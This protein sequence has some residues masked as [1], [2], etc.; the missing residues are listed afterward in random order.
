VTDLAHPLAPYASDLI[1]RIWGDEW[2][3]AEERKLWLAVMRFQA[4][5]GIEI[6][7]RALA[8]YADASSIDLD[9]IRQREMVTKHDVKA[10]LEEYNH[11]AS[12]IYGA[13]LELAH[14][15]MTSADVVDNISLVQMRRSLE[16][17]YVISNSEQER[18]L[19]ACLRIPFRGIKGPVGTQ[20][21]Q[22]DLLGSAEACNLLDTTCAA[23]W[24]F[25][26]VMNSVGQVYPRSIDFGV[27]SAV[28]F[29]C[30]THQHEPG[31]RSP[32]HPV[33]RGYFKM[34]GDYCDSQ[35]NEG[36]ISTSAIRRVALPGLFLAA[37]C[38]LRDV[39]P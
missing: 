33:L 23:I 9:S 3:I 32:W 11:V 22:L 13:P 7:P 10:R 12:K 15:G 30:S 14:L 6:P 29:A 38:L 31:E 1:Q 2:R 17:L 24:G 27:A 25:G 26:S 18:L 39:R 16:N 28:M 8:A 4:W 19:D 21:D 36:D 34:I 35:W 20:Q 5:H 37:D